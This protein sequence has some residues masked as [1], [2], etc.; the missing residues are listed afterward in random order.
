MRRLVIPLLIGLVVICSAGPAHSQGQYFSTTDTLGFGFTRFADTVKQLQDSII[1]IP[2]FLST[3]SMVTGLS[4]LFEFNPT[5]L[6]P[7]VSYDPNYQ[8]IYDS[9][10]ALGLED[11]MTDSTDWQPTPFMDSG[12]WN[13]DVEMSPQAAETWNA[14]WGT[15]QVLYN[16]RDRGNARFLMTP[17]PPAF[18]DDPNYVK[19]YLPGQMGPDDGGA[20]IAYM[21]FRVNPGATLNTYS[22][23][24]LTAEN[25]D[26]QKTE[27]AEEWFEEGVD[28]IPLTVAVIPTFDVGIFKVDTADTHT[29]PINVNDK[30]ILANITPKLY[31][32]EAG[33]QVSF[34]ISATDAEGGTLRIWVNQGTGLPPNAAVSPSNPVVG[35]SGVANGN[36]SFTPDITQAGSFTFKF[37]ALDDSGAV[38]DPQFVTVTVAGISY[39][40]LFTTSSEKLFPE[41]GVPGLNEV[42]VPVNIVTEKTIYGIQFDMNYDANNFDLDSIMPSDRIPNWVVYDNVGSTPGNLRVVTFGLSNDSMLTGSSSAVLYLV[43]TVDEFADFG[44]YPLDLSNAWESID[45]D[46]RVASLQLVTD[47][48]VVCVDRWG[49]VNLDKR[50][51]VADLVGMV[52]YI[53][54]TYDLSRRQFAAADVLVNDTVNVVDLVAVIN[55]IFL[56]IVPTPQPAPVLQDQFAALRVA[57][58][59]I[60]GGGVQSEMAVQADMPVNVAGVELEIQYNPSMVQMLRPL[61]AP[62]AD[63]FRIHYSDNGSG[64]MKVLIYSSHPWNESELIPEGL[65]DIVTLPFLAK[66]S[67]PAADGRQV[68]ITR[69]SVSTGSAVSVPVKGL[70]GPALPST[71][72]LYQNRPNPFNPGTTI[73]FYIDG[74]AE[75]GG[76]HIKLE[77]FNILGQMVRTLIDQPLPPG[78][79]SVSWDGTDDYGDRASS[80]VYLYRLKVGADSQTKKMVLLK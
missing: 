23:I 58:D 16:L 18:P 12:L 39:D 33:D 75:T 35:A 70:G 7:K 43:F 53:I 41:G 79:H 2:I 73:D 67:I 29:N 42:M 26:L 63:G 47:S 38:S 13:V 76:D 31:E 57:H 50:I 52:S 71:F 44:C 20:I 54:S 24:K 64:M 74:S 30:P 17:I 27:L 1:K 40:V 21:I 5:M 48:G 69:A 4:M 34:S 46:P 60:S 62:G 9:L 8:R 22:Q 25:E 32:V 77:I 66:G 78:Q 10:K 28:T 65:S 15:Y 37:Q 49:D 56:N 59:E 19:P 80:G 6:W 3:D 61:V 51:D 72:E 45:P 11:L 68:R 14:Q 55:A 36:F